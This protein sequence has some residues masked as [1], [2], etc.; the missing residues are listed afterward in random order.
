[1]ADEVDEILNDADDNFD[2]VFCEGDRPL[3]DHNY[4]CYLPILSTYVND[5]CV[6][7][8]GFVVRKLA[9]KLKCQVCRELLVAVPASHTSHRPTCFLKLKDNGGLVTPSE[10]VVQVIQRA[11]QN[12]RLLISLEKAVHNISRAGL[13]LEQAVLRDL[14]CA[15]VFGETSHL[16][17]TV[18]GIDNHVTSLVRQVVRF[19]LKI[20]KFHTVKMWNVERRK[21]NVRQKMTKLVLFRNE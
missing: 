21:S 14:D 17:D 1:M 18:S 11:E 12:Y 9:P 2:S 19:Y 20:R 6:Y 8:A 15:K 3:S 13:E 16:M 5:V 10:G 4:F 7:I